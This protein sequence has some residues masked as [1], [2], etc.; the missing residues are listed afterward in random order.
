ML[1]LE[2]MNVTE[3]EVNQEKMEA[4]PDHQQALNVELSVEINGAPEDR[5]GDQQP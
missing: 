2:E 1:E 4:V 3:S 5:Y